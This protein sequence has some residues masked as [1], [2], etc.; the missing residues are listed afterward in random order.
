MK[1]IFCYI[2]ALACMASAILSC[3]KAEE[4]ER[5][6]FEVTPATFGDDA[7]M[8]EGD[9]IIISI[10]TNQSWEITTDVDWLVFDAT[11]GTGD[12]DVFAAVKRGSQV[13][14]RN[15]TITVTA[16]GFDA[17]VLQLHQGI[18]VPVIITV[19]LPDIIAIGNTAEVGGSKELIE[20]SQAYLY[21]ASEAGAKNCLKDKSDIILTDGNNFIRATIPGAESF[22][23][24]DR[25]L[26]DLSEAK[27][28]RE[29]NG[30][31]HVNI[32]KQIKERESNPDWT[33]EP[34]YIPSSSIPAYQYALVKV[35]ICQA[36]EQYVGKKWQST[37]K[38][39]MTTYEDRDFELRIDSDASFSGS[40]VPEECGD[41]TGFVLDGKVCPRNAEDLSGLSSERRTRFSDKQ[42]SI[43]PIV[44]IMHIGSAANTF[45]NIENEGTTTMNFTELEGWSYDGASIHMPTGAKI[46]K[47]VGTWEPYQCCFTTTGWSVGKS[48][49]EYRIPIQEKTYGDLEFGFSMSHGTAG[50]LP[51]TYDIYYS[52]DGENFNPVDAV[53][54]ISPNEV[55]GNNRIIQKNN[56]HENSRYCAEFSIPESE[57][58]KKGDKLYVRATLAAAKNVYSSATERM[59]IGFYLATRATNQE[60]PM[61]DNVIASENFDNC[62]S[63]VSPVI[64]APVDYLTTWKTNTTYQSRN[65]WTVV[66]G[67]A[68]RKC[69]LLN[70]GSPA[71]YSPAFSRLH[72][73]ADVTLT[74]KA[75][76]YTD[77]I[78]DNSL[79]SSR[80]LNKIAVSV[81]GGG[82]AEEIVWDT[83]PESDYYNWH[84]ATV[85]ISGATPETVVA[86]QAQ[87]SSNKGAA[88]I[89]D[90]LILK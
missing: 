74:F 71:I 59:N 17:K 32:V 64:G 53:Y 34:A 23:F 40:I 84:N 3:T 69:F 44:N 11:S 39:D 29:D 52:T 83:D 51:W 35:G 45:S 4:T 14:D 19:E 56:A 79:S 85:K 1:K 76:L 38:M 73:T 54:C 66:G 27:I 58:L 46:S 68:S 36:Q 10:K 57:A 41:V 15:C 9:A 42:F 82:T 7:A 2:L 47:V 67:K 88:Y 20:F 90:I 55:E 22:K 37:V 65:G 31:F 60:V 61:Y 87:S 72:G 75:C 70:S 62:E 78:R 5:P 12:A 49:Y 6:Y 28:T 21:V 43:S 26:V 30:G 89:K 48:W 18:F 77:K 81:S 13:S 25:L 33:I 8:G 86:I 50:N 63:G 16:K 80:Q 24:G